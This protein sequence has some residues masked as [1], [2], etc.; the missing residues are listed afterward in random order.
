[1]LADID[2]STMLWEMFDDL[3]VMD[4]AVKLHHKTIREVLYKYSG[5]ES[6]TGQCTIV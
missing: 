3:D 6:A 1:M 5:Y 4:T 2:S